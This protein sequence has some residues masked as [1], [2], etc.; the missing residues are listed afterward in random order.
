MPP[1]DADAPRE[2]PTVDGVLALQARPC[3]VCGEPTRRVTL[4][5]DTLLPEPPYCGP[6]AEAAWDVTVELV[7]EDADGH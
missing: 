5:P 7:G 6:C 4:D 2:L 1:T 3:V